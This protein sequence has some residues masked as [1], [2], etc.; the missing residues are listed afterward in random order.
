[1]GFPKE[2]QFYTHRAGRTGRNE[3]DGICYVLY[4]EED[5][6]SIQSLS[7]QGIRFSAKE[8]KAGK[9]KSAV[10]PAAKKKDRFDPDEKEIA[11]T[12][13]RKNEKVK[14]NYKKKKNEEIERI[15][16]KKRREYIQGKI[17]EEK[18]ERYKAAAKKEREE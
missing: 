8:F 1:M 9:W 5:L 13:R 12:L 6:P 7:K 3:K 10:N 18:K 16:R 14:P 17:R 15:R 4:K 11:M 2:L